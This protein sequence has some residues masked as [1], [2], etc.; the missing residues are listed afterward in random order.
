MKVDIWS[1]IACP[2]CYLVKRNFETAM[3]YFPN[4]DQIEV[5]WHSFQLVPDAKSGT[6]LNADDALAAQAIVKVFYSSV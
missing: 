6:G 4:R 1:D 5:E 3:K 2:F